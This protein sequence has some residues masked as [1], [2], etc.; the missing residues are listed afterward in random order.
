MYYP[1]FEIDRMIWESWVND[2]TLSQE[3]KE[4]NNQLMNQCGFRF[5]NFTK[6]VTKK[7]KSGFQRFLNALKCKCCAR[8]SG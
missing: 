3:K 7:E 8:A 2:E 5:E 4:E 1:D 6:K